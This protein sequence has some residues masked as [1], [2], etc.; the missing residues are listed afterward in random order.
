[1][2]ENAQKTA[3]DADENAAADEKVTPK[4]ALERY[5]AEVWKKKSRDLTAELQHRVEAGDTERVR[6]LLKKHLNEPL[7]GRFVW[8][9]PHVDANDGQALIT[10][11][12]KG[13]ANIV[14]LLLD[15]GA[16]PSGVIQ[17]KKHG[18]ALRAA[19]RN[20]HLDVVKLL[21][22]RKADVNAKGGSWSSD[23][24]PL[25]AAIL[26][27]QAKVV[28][29]L[30]DHKAKP[31]WH[32]SE[33]AIK[34]GSAEVVR[35]L[36]DH[37]QD[38]GA[39]RMVDAAKAGHTK[40]VALLL[41]QGAVKG[42]SHAGSEALTH[43]AADG[44]TEMALKLIDAG[45][46]HSHALT[47][48]AEG[49][50]NEI[51]SRLLEI[52]ARP[53][54]PADN[55]PLHAAVASGYLDTAK[56]LLEGGADA[57]A[58]NNHAL[59]TAALHGNEAM[60]MLLLEHGAHIDNAIAHATTQDATGYL[61]RLKKRDTTEWTQLDEKTVQQTK[62]IGMDTTL[63]TIFNF[64]AGQVVTSVLHEK[65]VGLTAPVSSQSVQS[66][67]EMPQ[68]ALLEE[69]RTRLAANTNTETAQ[70]KQ[71]KTAPQRRATPGHKSG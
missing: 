5:D 48:A 21:V 47:L 40:T 66:V 31:D 20:G 25:D 2:A 68:K 60:S 44:H 11:C 45:A 9:K 34:S 65:G 15:A 37:G 29:Y 59:R 3:A 16:R 53:N 64:E 70:Q 51:V 57:A 10:A 23:K 33:Y 63:K 58:D 41:D 39:H 6:I 4:T 67:D 22:D 43:A 69:A 35:V 14:N 54:V 46:Y 24:S 8:R 17:T 30:L 32:T 50:Y 1:M 49:G 42:R 36:L 71:K 12:K 61:K 18:A 13:H 52:G 7:G 62:Y 19:A 56:L 28:E 38:I 26:A 55:R 27:G